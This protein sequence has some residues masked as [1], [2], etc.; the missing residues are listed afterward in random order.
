MIEILATVLTYVA[1]AASAL[2][3]ALVVANRPLLVDRWHGLLLLGIVALLEVGLLAQAV[4][5]LVKLFSDDRA[6]DGFAFVGYLVAPLLIL[7]L[8]AL[9]SLAERTRWGA[10]VMVIGCL[11]VPVMIVRLRQVWEAH[12]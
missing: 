2:A 3:A 5:G 1:L 9:W 8:A 6:V 11:T 12:G 4:G 7:P 10:G